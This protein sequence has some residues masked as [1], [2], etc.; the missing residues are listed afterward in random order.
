MQPDLR[1]EK[2][3]KI[4]QITFEPQRRKV[5]E[6]NRDKRRNLYSFLVYIEKSFFFAVSL[7]PL[8]LCGENDFVF[9]YVGEKF[10]LP[11]CPA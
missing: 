10:Y 5:R 9:R 2:L 6:E 11:A 8:R 7:R 3:N 4:R 1:T